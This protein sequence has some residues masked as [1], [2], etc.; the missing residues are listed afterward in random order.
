MLMEV[1]LFKLMLK[2]SSNMYLKYFI[3]RIKG[4]QILYIRIQDVL[5]FL[6][7]SAQLLYKKLENYLEAYGFQI[8][9]YNPYVAK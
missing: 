3:M 5:H 1:A 6:L 8:N 4:K 9:S 7:Q 2:V